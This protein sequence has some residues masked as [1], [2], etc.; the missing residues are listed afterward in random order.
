M[1]LAEF[2]NEINQLNTAAFVDADLTWITLTPSVEVWHGGSK[3]WAAGSP[4]TAQK[5][6]VIWPGGDQIVTTGDGTTKKLDFIL[7]GYHNAQVAVGDHW[8]E[9]PQRYRVE[10]IEPWNG[11]E[12]KAKGVSIGGTPA[13][14]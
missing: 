9:G 13:H 2:E 8:E 3:R 4:R 5:F 14:G 10:E 11:Y 7:V 1:T 12:V 6:K